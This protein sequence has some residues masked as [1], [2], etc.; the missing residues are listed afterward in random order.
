MGLFDF[1]AVGCSNVWH[2]DIKLKAS[3]IITSM[4]RLMYGSSWHRERPKLGRSEE[5]WSSAEETTHPS[6]S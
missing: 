6:A 4:L 2:I 1:N 3:S 5:R